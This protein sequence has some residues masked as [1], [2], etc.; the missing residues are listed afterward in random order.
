MV[1]QDMVL[2]NDIIVYNICYGCFDVSNEEV[3]E[4]VWMVQIYDFIECLLKGYQFEVGECGLKLLG[5][6]K[7]WV[8][9]V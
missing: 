4:V 7:Q 1:L 8:V 5:G 9:I 2:F 6:E 3:M